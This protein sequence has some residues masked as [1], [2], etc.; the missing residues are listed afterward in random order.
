MP[1]V[2]GEPMTTLPLVGSPSARSMICCAL[3]Q[4][5]CRFASLQLGVARRGQ[6]SERQ[7][8]IVNRLQKDNEVRGD[9]RRLDK[10]VLEDAR[11]DEA[12]HADGP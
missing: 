5:L 9:L 12:R 7:Q 2:S 11:R 4:P 6:D 3:S 8:R 10:A 1:M